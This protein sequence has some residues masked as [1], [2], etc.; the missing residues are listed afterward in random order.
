VVELWD[1]FVNRVR[2]F[3]RGR[4]YL[5]VSTPVLLEFPNLDPNVE[6]V[7]VEVRVKG[8]RRTFWLQ[9]SPEYTMK[10]MLAKYGKH[11]Y[12][13]TKCFRDNEYGR[14]H[15]PEFHML[16]WYRVGEDYRYLMEEIK[17]LTRL[18]L[19]W[20]S[21]QV[22]SV[23]EAFERFLSLPLSEDELE[24]RTNMEAC[25]Y[26][27]GED[28]DWETMFHRAYVELERK[29]RGEPPTFLT[30]FP[31]RVSALAKVRNGRA[32]RFEF[33]I[34]GVE[35]ANGWTEET[36]P[37]EVRRRLEREALTR[38]LPLDEE[39]IRSHGKMPECAGCSIGLDRLFMI[40]VGAESLDDIELW[41]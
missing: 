21:F 26:E 19:G 27:V 28:E 30:D 13:I 4:G 36:D 20:D 40:Y 22:L 11:I 7:K 34:R 31:P 37:K 9:T 23:E 12:Q 33:F 32:E 14:L 25:G 2:E 16:E 1:E 6:P 10:K 35:I 39:F 15:R 38:G 5:E 41:R 3:F 18:L 17:D 8:E 24:L 29:L